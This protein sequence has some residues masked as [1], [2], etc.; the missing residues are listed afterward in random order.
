[1]DRVQV[2]LRLLQL[3]ALLE[4][5]LQGGYDKIRLRLK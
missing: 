4:Q 3:L 1:M 2:A 5:L